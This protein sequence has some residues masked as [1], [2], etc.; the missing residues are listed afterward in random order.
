[1]PSPYDLLGR[2]RACLLGMR[3]TFAPSIAAAIAR[4]S[5]FGC[6]QD[7]GRFSELKGC[8]IARLYART[9]KLRVHGAI[10]HCC[11]Q[12]KKG[13]HLTRL[14]PFPA[15]G[16]VALRF[17]WSSRDP[18]AGCGARKMNKRAPAASLPFGR[19]PER[20]S[21]VRWDFSIRDAQCAGLEPSRSDPRCRAAPS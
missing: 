1:M 20:N 17:I 14:R 16:D 5:C 10:C 19:K 12:D 15:G 3:R 4:N 6:L 13:E 2:C 11:L 7:V 9:L 8:S 21:I 18:A